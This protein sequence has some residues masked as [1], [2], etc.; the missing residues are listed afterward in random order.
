MS[1]ASP[2][3]A[4][5]VVRV[6]PFLVALSGASALVYE[7]VWMRSFGLIFGNTTDAVAMV[8]A[9]FMGGLAL[10]SALAARRRS[11]DPLLAYARIE[12]SVGG[13]ALA[14]LPLL[15]AVP[16]AYGALAGRLGLEGPLELLGRAALATVVLLAPTV[17]LGM[18]VPLAVEFL[19]RAGQPVRASFGRLYLLN[20]LGGALGVALAPF[21]LVPMLGVHGTLVAAAAGSLLVGGVARGLRRDMGPPPEITRA[22]PAEEAA[23]PKTEATLETVTHAPPP[24]ALAPTLALASGAAT[25]GVEVLWTRSYALVIGSSVYAFNLMLLAVLLG[26]AGGAALYARVRPR[27]A[28]P[29]VA[30]GGLFLAAGVFVLVGETAIGQ[31]PRFYLGALKV[32]PIS[33]AAH[34]LASLG[35]CLVTMLPVTLV[36]G[37]TFP[38]LLHLADTRGSAQEA[39]GRLYAWNTAGAIAGAL[40]AD[41]LLVPR[42][43]L[44]PPYLVY[45]TLLI[46]GGAWALAS[47]TEWSPLR[48]TAVPAGLVAI[49]LAASPWWKPW[50]PVLMS[51]GVHRYGLEWRDR[52]SS[53]FSL[54]TWLREQQELVFYREGSEAVVAVSKTGE[55]RHF[56]SVNGKTD[57]GS[58]EEDVVTQRF[59]AHVPMLLHLFPEHVL[60]IGWGAGATAASAALYPVET[61]ECVEIEPAVYEA[62]SFFDELSGALRRD[63]RFRITFRDGRNRLLRG[64]ER[65]DVIVSEPSNPWISGVSNLFTRDFYE[66]VRRRLAPGGVFGQWFHYYNLTEPDLKVEVNTF[67]KVFPHASL[68]M[69]PPVETADGTRKLGADMLLVGSEAPH[70]FD[71]DRLQGLMGDT[72]VGRDLR[73]T[74]AI[75]DAWALVAAWT[76]GRPEMEKWIVDDKDFPGG[77]PINTDD[78]PYVEFVAPRRNVIAPIEAARAASAQHASISSAAGDARGA[79]RGLLPEEPTPEQVATVYRELAARYARAEQKQRAYAALEDAIAAFPDDARARVQTAEL[80]LESGRQVE[81]LAQL[82]VAVQIDPDLVHGWDLLEEIAVQRRDYPLAEKANRA[83]LRRE[84]TNVDAWLRLAAVL[85]RQ[86]EWGPA[87]DALAWARS[88]DKDAPVDAELERY[89][90]RRATEEKTGRP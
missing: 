46:G 41:L 22:P 10:G 51:A 15:Q 5:R 74:H 78:H 79:V 7:S 16:W 34:Q 45:A 40:T 35:L 28:R 70:A 89:I 32:L 84:P 55:G 56:L 77:T 80:M 18:T 73:A 71:W 43:G 48:R 76:M 90:A 27:I 50:D 29:A 72:P 82:A 11:S 69:V 2:S 1:D 88:L 9:V 19:A 6:V 64:T 33:F 39:S 57:A 31:L 86:S 52:V 65:W 8:L 62:A 21:V 54:G 38:L 20:T 3:P 81:A 63:P 17:L 26:I 68:W 53:I 59:I 49:L 13:V 83:I 87:H 67:L 36:L 75:D 12:L 23:S 4:E 85:A 61:V 47:A 24:P 14:T 58:G 37:L 44:E 60:V 66:A 25:F 30:V 42:L